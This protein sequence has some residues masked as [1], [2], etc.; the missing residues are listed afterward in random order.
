MTDIVRLCHFNLIATFQLYL[1]SHMIYAVI[2]TL[3]TTAW[4]QE[5]EPRRSGC[6]ETLSIEA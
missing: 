6:R 1:A 3:G 2:S 4:T 5:L